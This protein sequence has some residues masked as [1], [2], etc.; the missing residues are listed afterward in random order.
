LHASDVNAQQ[1]NM[2]WQMSYGGSTYDQAESIIKTFDGGYIMTGIATSV[3]G[4]V[5]SNH[6]AGDVWVVKTD[7]WGGIQ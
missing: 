6:G 2:F 4:D 1:A 5:T 7:V 3:D